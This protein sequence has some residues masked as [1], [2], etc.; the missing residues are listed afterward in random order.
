MLSEIQHSVE[1]EVDPLVSLTKHSS[2][3]QLKDDNSPPETITIKEIFKAPCLQSLRNLESLVSTFSRESHEEIDDYLHSLS[4]NSVKNVS[5][6][7]QVLEKT[8]FTQKTSSSL[9]ALSTASD[10][11]QKLSLRQKSAIFCEQIHDNRA[12]MEKSQVATSEDEP[13]KYADITLKEVIRKS[14]VPLQT[15]ILKSK[16]EVNLPEPLPI[17]AQSKS[18]QIDPLENLI[19]QLRRELVFLRSQVS[20]PPNHIPGIVFILTLF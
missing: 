4:D 7:H 1:S 10:L 3:V 14:E 2:S 17:T 20:F 18:S 8:S 9:Q 6:S 15:E 5:R 13:I 12:D 11:M 19:E 16:L